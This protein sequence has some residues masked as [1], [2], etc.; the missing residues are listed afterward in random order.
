MQFALAHLNRLA[1]GIRARWQKALIRGVYEQLNREGRID[2]DFLNYGYAAIGAA[3]VGDGT[4][5]PYGIQLYERVASPC[6]LS[7]ADVLEVGSGRGGGSAFLRWNL[8]A[9]SVTG[10]DFSRRAVAAATGQHRAQ[11]LRFL[12]VDAE[13]LPFRA[14][15]F[16]AVV[17][18]ESSHC[19][20]DFERFLSEV[21]RVL[22]PGGSL[23]L[24]DLRAADEVAVLREQ[25]RRGGFVILE[26]ESIAANVVRALELDSDRRLAWV[27]RAVPGPLRGAARDFV[28]A[29]GS[30]VLARLRA[31]S[32]DYVRLAL[33]KSGP[34]S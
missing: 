32:L 12:T 11:G 23:L 9:R 20:P 27:R 16:D 30:D 3:A 13:S 34:P 2:V 26:D 21:S 25:C 19:Y 5:E 4:T 24:A 6:D 15:S 18:V 31:G 29:E 10:V 8:G 22:R 33:R 17:N 14:A 1:P 28:G 7:G